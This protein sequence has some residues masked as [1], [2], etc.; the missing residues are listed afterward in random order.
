[1]LRAD[2]H[3]KRCSVSIDADGSVT[4]QPGRVAIRRRS[5]I[6]ATA[7][8]IALA[9]TIACALSL[10]GGVLF[11]DGPLLSFGPGGLWIGLTPDPTG[12]RVSLTVFSLGQRLAGALAVVVLAAPV[13]F[14]PFHARVL[15]RLYGQGTVFAPANARRLKLIG[16]GLISY[17]VAPFVAHHVI[18]L[19]G[20]T[21]DPRWFHFDEAIAL[22]FGVVVF[23]IANVMEFGCEI[24]QE[25]DGF[26]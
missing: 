5:R 14:I 22:I 25:R 9:L 20:V 23:V 15:F 18:I 8:T 6:S 21:N 11:Y 19:A 12:G 17:S 3:G 10:V 26:I 7:L 13:A 24:E 2:Y 1:M 16:A 4:E